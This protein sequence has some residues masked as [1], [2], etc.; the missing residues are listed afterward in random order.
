M[1]LTRSQKSGLFSTVVFHATLLLILFYLGF[2][3][4][5][6]A[7]A[8]EGLLVDFGNSLNGFGTEEPSAAVSENAKNKIQES[9]PESQT[10]LQPSHKVKNKP[11]ANES[12]EIFTQD[13]EKTAAIVARKKA[14]EK[15]KKELQEERNLKQQLDEQRREEKLQEEQ[16]LAENKRK[17]QEA[18]M[19]GAINS[20][21]KN[22]FGGGKT[23][24]G[25]QSKGQGITYGDGNMGSPNG[26]PGVNR[27]GQGGGIGNGQGV[28]FNLSGRSAQSLPKPQ[29][30]GNESAIVVVEVTVDK[31]GKVSK[32]LP[33]IKGSNTV[34]PDLLEAARKAAMSASFNRDD[35]APA[36][37]KGSIT[38]RFILQ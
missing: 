36:F 25:S 30:P 14:D 29:F 15:K 5:N 37:Q 34:N 11:A 22:A 8:E 21:A 23:V 28:S 4:P 35:N 20:R 27:Y 32:A 18:Q 16:E 26:T 10:P 19:I 2:T 6:Q 31:F 9:L 3:V 12:D 1:A 38:Y 7:P 13:L 24:N 17:A 33:G